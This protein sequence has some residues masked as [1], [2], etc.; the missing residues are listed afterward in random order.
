MTISC[1]LRQHPSCS[2]RSIFRFILTITTF[3]LLYTGALHAT[4]AATLTVPAGGDVQSAINAAQPGD[5]ILLQAG[6]SFTGPFTLIDK[7]SP[8]PDSSSITIRT[9]APDSALPAS[10]ERISPAYAA[11][12]PKL[13]SPGNNMSA[14]QTAASAH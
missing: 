8:N 7:S 1:G 3:L 5:T 13:L 11:V 10:T 9:S 14:L 12:M 6:A 4:H 2:F